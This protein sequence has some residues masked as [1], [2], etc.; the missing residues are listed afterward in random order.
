MR[1]GRPPWNPDEKVIAEV[2]R[3][4][5][6]GLTMEQIAYNLG[7]SPTTLYAKKRV[8]KQFSEA[9]KRGTARANAV[10]VNRLF[11]AAMNG[12]IVAMIC[13]T[14]TRMGWKESSSMELSGPNAGP[15]AV[16]PVPQ[17]VLR[18]EQECIGLETARILQR[19]GALPDLSD[20]SGRKS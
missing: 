16:T 9:I 8:F 11:E 4:G 18:A 3:M 15:I 20:D 1:G 6:L 19:A 2:E 13:W 12:H 17:P 10:V 14:K 5:G 7:I